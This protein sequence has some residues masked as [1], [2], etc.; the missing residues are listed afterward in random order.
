MPSGASLSKDDPREKKL[1]SRQKWRDKLFAGENK[2]DSKGQDDKESTDQDIA[3]FLGNSTLKDED[4]LLDQAPSPWPE[5]HEATQ[6]SSQGRPRSPP[7][8][9]NIYHRAR[10]RQNKGLHV[11]FATTAPQIIGEGGDEADAPPNIISARK[12]SL[13]E[14]SVPAEEPYSTSGSTPPKVPPKPSQG[15]TQGFQRPSLALSPSDQGRRLRRRSVQDIG[16]V[17]PNVLQNERPDKNG[18]PSPVSPV[19]PIS[20][21]ENYRPPNNQYGSQQDSS[22]LRIP[23]PS[24]PSDAGNSL[25]PRVS[26]EPSSFTGGLLE[27][28]VH[29][30]KEL[31]RMRKKSPSDSNQLLSPTDV[32]SEKKPVSAS[33]SAKQKSLRDVAKTIGLEAIDEFD[34]RVSRFFEIFRL[35]VSTLGDPMNISFGRWLRTAMW[36]FLKGRGELEAEVR[37][38]YKA[39]DIS[40][41]TDTE[42]SVGL[43]QAYVDLAKA[44]WIVKDIT[45]NHPDIRRYGNTSV[46]SMVAILHNFGNRELASLAKCHVDIVANLRALAMSMKRNNRLPPETLEIQRL[47]IRVLYESARLPHDIASDLV[48][49]QTN[50]HDRSL[51]FNMPLGDTSKFFAFSRMFGSISMSSKHDPSELV[52]AIPCLVSLLRSKNST[53][54]TILIS[55]QDESINISIEEAPPPGLG[56]A[57]KNVSWKAAENCLQFTLSNDTVSSITLPEADFK[58][59]WS[60]CDYTRKV[61]KDFQGR[62]GEE[63]AYEATLQRFQCLKHSSHASSFPT[64][65]IAHCRIRLFSIWR[66]N[67]N[68][69]GR[70]RAG[71]RLMAKSPSDIKSLS[72][73]SQEYNNDMPT[74]LGFDSRD[75]APR[76]SVRIPG[77]STFVLSFHHHEDLNLFFDIFLQRQPAEDELR[78]TPL[79]LKGLQIVTEDPH[80]KQDTTH[81]QTVQWQQVKVISRRPPM[82]QISSPTDRFHKLRLILKCDVGYVTDCMGLRKS[83]DPVYQYRVAD[84]PRAW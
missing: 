67:A 64:D 77:A 13:P 20:D 43:R 8:P 47:D 50:P 18:F 32:A 14:L 75:D 3:N 37:T 40:Q 54:L 19:S 36:W 70:I 81:L 60:I 31:Q 10:P 79:T 23:S 62:R 84:Y 45:P 66:V 24:D 35:G 51:N 44:W 7:P 57:W 65:P 22:S 39:A 16:D 5:D 72:S 49:L 28:R 30:D 1:F 80:V 27:D 2:K 82:Q 42:V 53:D 48:A 21:D 26:P 58:G 59:I 63:V 11:G 83:M 56:L 76:L 38:R 52:A 46:K 9:Q 17:H 73:I 78:S 6:S 68:G 69:S 41:H 61:Q 15:A 55:S 74:L 25:T 33:F 12:F 71:H 4:R 29:T 34:M